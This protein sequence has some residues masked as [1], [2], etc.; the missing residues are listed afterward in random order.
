MVRV[1]VVGAGYW[2][3]NLIRNFYACP[4]AILQAIC[5]RDGARLDH[6]RRLYPAVDFVQDFHALLGRPDID[7]V[8]VATPPATHGPISLAALRAGK[9][10]LV[11]K[12]LANS[13]SQAEE[14]VHEAK[15]RGLTLMVDHTFIYSPA[16]Q[17]I[18][19]L[20]DA[21]EIGQ[22]YYI[23][24]VRINLGLFQNDVNVLWD[25]VPH[26]LSIV[27][28]L[29]GRVPVGLSAFGA[30]HC[31]RL[32]QMEDVAYLTLDFGNNLVASFHVNW[33]SPVKI[34]QFIIGGSKKSIVYNDLEPMEKLKVYERGI[35]VANDL[36]AKHDALVSYRMGD[37]WSP[38]LEQVEALQVMARHFVSCVR[39]GRRPI[40]DGESGLRVVRILA[41]SQQSIKSQ[42]VRVFLKTDL[43]K[44][45]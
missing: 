3:P 27:D 8:V 18:K 43:P 29:L 23:D 16:V 40:T 12:P 19:E 30:S 39:E 38:H 20:M 26:D 10:V 21:D 37:V 31:G 6:F 11:E 34:R 22:I 13:V 4:G 2:G 17:K 5:D 41:S 28:Y 36:E 45:A 9:H 7:A 15:V 24:S 42:G 32:R 35:D 1:A 14:L 33:L 25:L 44:V